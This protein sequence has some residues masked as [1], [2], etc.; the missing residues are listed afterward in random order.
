M[1]SPFWI[2]LLENDI[3]KLPEPVKR[4]ARKFRSATNGSSMQSSPPH[5][6]T[7]NTSYDGQSSPVASRNGD[8]SVTS[9][10]EFPDPPSLQAFRKKHRKPYSEYPPPIIGHVAEPE[11]RYW[12]EYDHP[13][14]EEAGYYIYVDPNA[15]VKF[16]GQELLEAWVRRTKQLFGMRDKSQLDSLSATE[17]SETDDDTVDEAPITGAANYGTMPISHQSTTHDGY[18]SNLF[19]SLRNPHHE[20]DMFHERRSLLSE[21][22]TR[23]HKTEMTK[24]RLYST[25]LATAIVIDIILGLMT[26][27]SR[28]R[29]RGVV[30]A[31]VLFGTIVTLILC[32]VATVSMKTRKERLGW[33][34]QGA[35]LSI[36]GAVVAL[37]VLLLLWVLR[38]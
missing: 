9:A 12:N 38:I 13:E 11:Q 21:L 28:K 17:D 26:V 4:K 25:C 29:E 18:F 23:L 24:L 3:R 8:S 19:R 30:D 15:S 35:T 10:Q 34:H 5:T 2:P 31:V 32:G 6:S 37:D 22:E 14:D 1:S 36:A 27:T 33:V 7:S 16:P 20:A